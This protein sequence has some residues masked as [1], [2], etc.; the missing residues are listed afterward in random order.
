V[1][2]DIHPS[3]Y[4]VLEPIVDGEIN[5]Q[6]RMPVHEFRHTQNDLKDGVAGTQPDA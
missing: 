6:E 3:R 4:Q 2:R 5:P 1:L